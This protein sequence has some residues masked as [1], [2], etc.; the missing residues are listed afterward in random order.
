MIKVQWLFICIECLNA[1]EI[2]HHFIYNVP[3]LPCITSYHYIS[4]KGKSHQVFKER[5]QLLQ[6]VICNLFEKLIFVS[7]GALKP[8]QSYCFS[9]Q[10]TG[11]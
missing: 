7:Y 2:T 1:Q 8:T 10:H 6:I 5:N 4:F 3:K 9:K 11:L